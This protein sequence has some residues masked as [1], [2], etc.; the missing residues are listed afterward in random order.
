MIGFNR[1]AR[2]P[3]SRYFSTRFSA[4]RGEV[5]GRSLAG[6]RDFDEKT[7]PGLSSPDKRAAPGASCFSRRTVAPAHP[8]NPEPA[9]K[10]RDDLPP[11][12]RGMQCRPPSRQANPPQTDRTEPV[13]PQTIQGQLL[14]T[15]SRLGG[16]ACRV[17]RPRRN[18]TLRNSPARRSLETTHSR[19][20]HKTTSARP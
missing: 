12:R 1:D 11:L 15:T 16:V 20:L 8:Q 14:E 19:R 6:N 13:P 3:A 9:L 4:Q 10:W 18:R 5:T 17:V 2:R 7:E